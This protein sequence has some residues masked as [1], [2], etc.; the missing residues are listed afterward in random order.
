MHAPA[1][2]FGLVYTSVL[3]SQK[4]TDRYRGRAKILTKIARS[5]LFSNN[6]PGLEPLSPSKSLSRIY[7]M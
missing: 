2:P 6:V 5:E 3:L 1:R 4:S 7:L